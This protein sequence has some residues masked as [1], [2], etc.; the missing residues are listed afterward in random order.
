M[1]VSLKDQNMG[2]GV[3]ISARAWL[4]G[5]RRCAQL[6]WIGYTGVNYSA[7]L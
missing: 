5:Q 4:S 3:A 1:E 6:L 2:G 7:N